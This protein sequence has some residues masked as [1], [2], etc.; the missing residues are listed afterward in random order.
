MGIIGFGAIGRGI[1]Q[2]ALV[3][4]MNVMAI[5]AFPL[6]GSILVDEVWPISRR[7]ELIPLVVVVAAPLTVKTRYLIGT[8]PLALM[9]DD[10]H[11]IVVSRVGIV[12]ESAF[13]D[14]LTNGELAGVTLDVAGQEPLPADS[15]LRDLP[16]FILTPHLAGASAPKERR[17][18][19]IFRDNLVRYQNGDPLINVVDKARGF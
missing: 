8:E 2:R 19:E 5:D 1:A 11:L 10:A 7:D 16:R 18:V 9:N 6:N 13:A 12:D 17:V 15:Q 3:F 4:D 14:T